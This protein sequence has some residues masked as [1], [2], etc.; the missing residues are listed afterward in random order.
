ML[1][2]WRD[3]GSLKP[4]PNHPGRLYS[5]HR[6][7][8]SPFPHRSPGRQDG[9][10]SRMSRSPGRAVSGAG[11]VNGDEIADLLI[12]PSA[13]PSTPGRAMW[14]SG[15]RHHS[16]HRRQRDGQ[17]GNDVQEDAR[18]VCEIVHLP[19]AQATLCC[20][21][22]P[23]IASAARARAVPTNAP[24]RARRTI[25]ETLCLLLQRRGSGDSLSNGEYWRSAYE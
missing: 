8:A 21:C 23:A 14:S 15:N 5:S 4:A 9:R 18:P 24:S 12:G 20:S 10:A 19:D 25:A 6:S 1:A 13:P 3:S 2:T 17:G 7:E 22:W 16:H 11:D